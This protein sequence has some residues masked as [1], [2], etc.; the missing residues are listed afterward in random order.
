VSDTFQRSAS[1][2]LDEA[3]PAI[4][5]L[6]AN[7]DAE[8]VAADLIEAW[9]AAQRVLRELAENSA[10]S[11]QALIRVLRQRQLLTLDQAHALVEFG[12]VHERAQRVD[13]TPTDA[14]IAAA[15][16]GF[17]QL[18]ALVRHPPA[19]PARREVPAPDPRPVDP[20]VTPDPVPPPAR[21]TQRSTVVTLVI[22]I[23][24]WLGLL[25]GGAWYYFVFRNAAGDLQRGIT[26]YVAGDRTTA[27][28]AFTAVARDHPEV[29]SPHIYLGRMAREEGDIATAA[30]ELETAVRLE[31]KSAQ[32]LREMGAHL[33]ASGIGQL[34]AGNQAAAMQNFDLARRFYIRALQS[35]SSDR[36]A[37]GF[38]GC[39]LIRL[40]RYD[41][42]RRFL[43]RAGQGSWSVCSNIA[44][45]APQVIPP[46]R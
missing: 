32:A 16:A 18:E 25:G 33:L 19:P 7:R 28:A 3:R 23:V 45:P 5:R 10:L 29:A 13:Y 36:N 26:A 40:G 39:T 17:Q 27:K 9:D 46:A 4:D 43:E 30:R 21:R 44:P 2:A 1:A 14:D 31:P 12:A 34:N 20:I 6:D 8:D 42:G 41:E 11:G 37:Q 35:N 38:L 22:G 24:V 15:R